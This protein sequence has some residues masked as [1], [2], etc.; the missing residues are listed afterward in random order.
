LSC[1]AHSAAVGQPDSI[2][3]LPVDLGVAPAPVALIWRRNASQATQA[4]AALQ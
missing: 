1:C 4:V 2:A 3:L